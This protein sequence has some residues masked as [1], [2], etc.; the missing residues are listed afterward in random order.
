[1]ARDGEET[2]SFYLYASPEHGEDAVTVIVMR[3]DG[4]KTVGRT[5][6]IIRH[7]EG[8]VTVADDLRPPLDG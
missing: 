3:K 6:Y 7:G 5:R 8:E 4:S 2:L 1:M